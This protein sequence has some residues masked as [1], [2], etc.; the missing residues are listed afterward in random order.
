MELA[1]GR[2][3]RRG[4]LPTAALASRPAGDRITVGGVVTHRQ[5]PDS[6]AAVPRTSR[7][8]PAWS[9][10]SARGRLD[11]VEAGSPVAPGL[12]G[13]GADRAVRGVDDLGGGAVRPARHWAR[14][15]PPEISD[16]S[17]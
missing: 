9:M 6:A 3:D 14:S 12:A 17:S 4:V 8:R 13:A 2:L 1:R 11:P 15:P 16:D 5:Q 10:S 7:T